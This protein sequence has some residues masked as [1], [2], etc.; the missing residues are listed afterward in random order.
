M[1]RLVQAA[2]AEAIDHCWG[3]IEAALEPGPYVLGERFSVADIYLAMVAGWQIDKPKMATDRPSVRRMVDMVR[4][5]PGIAP[6]WESHY[7]H[8]EV[9]MD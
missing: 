2:R 9:F 6:I 4:A 8:K 7:G 1:V 5:R 3:T